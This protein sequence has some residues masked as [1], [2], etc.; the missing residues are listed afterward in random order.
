MSINYVIKK[1]ATM[2]LHIYIIDVIMLIECIV[3]INTSYCH[4][5]LIISLH[6][7]FY[8]GIT[9]SSNRSNYFPFALL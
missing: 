1:W 2:F 3:S 9:E 7:D 8:N 5:A 4:H 6:C